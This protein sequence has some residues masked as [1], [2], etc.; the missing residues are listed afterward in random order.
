MDLTEL[1]MQLR[2]LVAQNM[3]VES[4]VTFI[5]FVI[6]AWAVIYVL[7]RIIGSAVARTK[8]EVD[9]KIF[10]R[11]NKYIPFI[12]ILY[13]LKFALRPL[14]LEPGLLEI[15]EKGIS[16][17]VILIFMR[18][19][20][21]IANVVIDGWGKRWAEKTKSTVDDQL[22]HLLHKVTGILIL[23]GTIIFIL[24]TWKINVT[25]LVASLGIAGIA[26]AFALQSTLGNLF[27][28]ISIIIDKS[29]KV[30]DVVELDKDTIG[31]VLD[32]GLRSTKIKTFD[33]EVVIVP[34]GKLADARIKNY[35]KPDVSARLVIPFNVAYGSKV[36]KVKGVVLK[37]I[38]N[39]DGV[40]KDPKPF[41]RFSEMTDSSLKFKAYIW[42]EDYRN[43]FSVKDVANTKIYNALNR[44]KLV[45][46]FPQLDVHLKKR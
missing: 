39:I 42:V 25:P 16:T 3:Y 17:V 8:T 20:T 44:A 13:G 30:G 38:K 1:Y 41:I 31:T 5:S 11:I 34:N 7:E 4:I 10:K 6:V 37:E 12:V 26:V 27:G 19:A 18:I 22:I 9:D 43:R 29:V 33:N 32:V 23:I 45:I 24:D 2:A 28:G 21:Q 35:V 40:L 14:V 15:I 46:P 36:D